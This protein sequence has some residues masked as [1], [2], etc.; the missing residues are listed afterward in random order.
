MI[1]TASTNSR[2]KEIDV[3]VLVSGTLDQ[4]IL[5]SAIS[6]GMPT[7][8]HA[9]GVSEQGAVTLEGERVAEARA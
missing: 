5:R 8:L 9:T 7:Y 2:Q 6:S 4:S 1:N 3:D